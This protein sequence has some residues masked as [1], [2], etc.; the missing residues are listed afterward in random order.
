MYQNQ[1]HLFYPPPETLHDY[2]NV[3]NGNSFFKGYVKTYAVRQKKVRKLRGQCAD[4]KP[5]KAQL[6]AFCVNVIV[7]FTYCQ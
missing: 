6:I 5:C 7:S 1:P 4:R 3:A 2:I